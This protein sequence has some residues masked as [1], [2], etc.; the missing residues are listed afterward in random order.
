M[1]TYI[2]KPDMWFDAGTEAFLIAEIVPGQSG[3]FLGTRDGKPDEESC[4]YDE[5]EITE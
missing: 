4:G 5:F 2:T 1:T 3:L